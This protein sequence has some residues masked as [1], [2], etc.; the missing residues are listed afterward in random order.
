MRSSF[1]EEVEQLSMVTIEFV[2]P[3]D[4]VCRAL[5]F[6]DAA[7]RF[8]P[9]SEVSVMVGEFE[10]AGA[11]DLVANLSGGEWN[12]HTGGERQLINRLC[13]VHIP[14]VLHDVFAT[15]LRRQ[16][17]KFLFG[18]ASDGAFLAL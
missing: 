4:S 18:S 17:D 1:R 16:R 7:G 12:T 6:C 10:S 3:L 13:L 2:L 11:F 14:I 15:Q 9:T 5:L 8:F